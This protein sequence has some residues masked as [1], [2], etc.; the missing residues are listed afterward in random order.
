M[1]DHPRVCGEKRW[2]SR[3]S[4]WCQGSP[5]RM[6]GKVSAGATLPR[7]GGITP[8]YA[9]KSLLTIPK[10]TTRRD[11]PRVCGEKAFISDSGGCW[12]GSPPRMRGKVHSCTMTRF[13]GRI[14]PAYAGKSAQQ[15]VQMW[16]VRD[17]PRVCGEKRASSMSQ[18]LLLGSPPRMR[19]KE[20]RQSG[21]CAA[22]GITP[23]YAGKRN[24]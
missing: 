6:R 19:G 22:L 5:P 17:H 20:E 18:T 14:T 2:S 7:L 16:V 4:A 23:A 9:G 11:H 10:L 12:S 15:Q 3:T 1:R 21:G 8:A 24:R 13:S